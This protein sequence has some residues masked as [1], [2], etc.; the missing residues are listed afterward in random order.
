M[1]CFRASFPSSRHRHTRLGAPEADAEIADAV[2]GAV[3]P[4]RQGGGMGR[5]VVVAGGGVDR[6]Q[7]PPGRVAA[8]DLD[9]ALIE[10]GAVAL[11]APAD[12]DG[13]GGDR[14]GDLRLQGGEV[15]R[16]LAR[17]DD[18][19]VLADRLG[20]ARAGLDRL[21]QGEELVQRAVLAE[22]SRNDQ[23]KPAASVD[24]SHRCSFVDDFVRLGVSL[25]Y[26]RSGKSICSVSRQRLS[27]IGMRQSHPDIRDP[28][29]VH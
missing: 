19:E 21:D 13:G 18:A 29:R 26:E 23:S 1:R 25:W 17:A 4:P 8:V 22:G 27:F 24:F 9:L 28:E 10:E 15:G 14:G 7:L 6:Q 2:D 11:P 5:R 16:G 12:L 20:V 3:F